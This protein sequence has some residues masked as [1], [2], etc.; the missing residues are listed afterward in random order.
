MLDDNDREQENG[1]FFE[2]IEKLIDGVIEDDRL[3]DGSMS[4][5]DFEQQ[6][7]DMN[8]RSGYVNT[9][10]LL[11]ML[12]RI[13]IEECLDLRAKAEQLA[14]EM[15]AAFTNKELAKRSYY[16]DKLKAEK[17]KK[18]ISGMIRLHSTNP[19]AVN[20]FVSRHIKT[21]D[22]EKLLKAHATELND[23]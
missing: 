4:C 15:L 22:I 12:F 23:V 2:Y 14:R 13:G 6:L 5:L 9:P 21:V 8:A 1:Q 16:Q 20:A 19:D 3:K 18:V 17:R 7:Y 11:L 10:G